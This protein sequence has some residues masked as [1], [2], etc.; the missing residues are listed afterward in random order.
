LV[1]NACAEPR[2]SSGPN[3]PRCGATFSSHWAASRHDD[4]ARGNRRVSA[5]APTAGAAAQHS[6][7]ARPR[8]R[9][10]GNPRHQWCAV[11]SMAPCSKRPATPPQPTTPQWPTS[12]T[13]KCQGQPEA[14]HDSRGITTARTRTTIATWAGC[15]KAEKAQVRCRIAQTWRYL[16]ERQSG[17][18]TPPSR[19]SSH[20]ADLRGRPGGKISGV[21]RSDL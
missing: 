16:A 15:C 19:T 12:N 3:W 9:R 14:G 7:R 5:A 1:A 20:L 11:R 8:P 13:V 10:A 17:S 18:S 2:H 6:H 21:N 4:P